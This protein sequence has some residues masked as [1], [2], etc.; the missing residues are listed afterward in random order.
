MAVAY[1]SQNANSTMLMHWHESQQHLL[2]QCCHGAKAA[3]A[4]DGLCR[5]DQVIAV[6]QA[7]F[8]E[9]VYQSLPVSSK[10]AS[11]CSS[12]RLCLATCLL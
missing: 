12:P 10:V 9:H 7:C 1:C 6:Q 11:T 3:L 2:Q 5:Q 4:V 8:P